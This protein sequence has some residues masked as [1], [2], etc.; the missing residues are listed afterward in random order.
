LISSTKVLAPGGDLR[1]IFA[2][3]TIVNGGEPS[4]AVNGHFWISA[5]FL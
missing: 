1:Y 4:Q 5:G 2:N 3:I